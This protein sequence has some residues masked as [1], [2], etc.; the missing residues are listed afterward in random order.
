MLKIKNL[1]IGYKKRHVVTISD[2]EA[3]KGEVVMIYGLMLE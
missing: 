2:F 3:K 1:K